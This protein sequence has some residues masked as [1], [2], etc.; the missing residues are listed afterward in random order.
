MNQFLYSGNFKLNLTLPRR[1]KSFLSLKPCLT[2]GRTPYRSRTHTHIHTT[3]E[4]W[5]S[6]LMGRHTVKTTGSDANTV[7]K[8][9][10]WGL[11]PPQYLLSA[12]TNPVLSQRPEDAVLSIQDHVGSNFTKHDKSLK[13][14]P[15]HYWLHFLLRTPSQTQYNPPPLS[16]STGSTCHR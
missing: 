14:K 1:V 6:E 12:I 4:S 10:V 9:I 8:I 15:K 13:H 7:D 16:L 3:R 11:R 5:C 2:L